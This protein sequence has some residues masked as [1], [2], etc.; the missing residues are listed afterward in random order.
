MNMKQRFA[1]FLALTGILILIQS[2]WKSAGRP[3]G[4]STVL[5]E[6]NSASA[7]VKMSEMI[8]QLENA[9]GRQ[10]GDELRTAFLAVNLSQRT[11]EADVAM[12][13]LAAGMN[14]ENDQIRANAAAY[15]QSLLIDVAHGSVKVDSDYEPELAGL[16]RLYKLR[17]QDLIGKM[18]SAFP[19][20]RTL[21]YLIKVKG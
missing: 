13:K 14:S 1:I 12:A 10:A 16:F 20:S 7:R 19:N 4:A 2:Y 6:A 3:A 8:K 18:R 21:A 5:T 17:A 9:P 15:V 11:P